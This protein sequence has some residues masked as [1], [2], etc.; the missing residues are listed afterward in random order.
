MGTENPRLPDATNTNAATA[1][2]EFESGV[3]EPVTGSTLAVDEELS[4]I[5]RFVDIGC[6]APRVDSVNARTETVG[7]PAV[8]E[9]R[10]PMVIDTKCRLAN[11]KRV[12]PPAE[13]GS[14]RYVGR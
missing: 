8:I 9:I 11:D 10:R 4:E 3:D 2:V 5:A 6:Q 1:V 12:R 14:D 7:D 13:T